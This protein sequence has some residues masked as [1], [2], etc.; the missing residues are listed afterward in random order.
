MFPS[1]FHPYPQHIPNPNH[2]IAKHGNGY[3]ISHPYA[4]LLPFP[5]ATS[6]QSQLKEN[7]SSTQ[8]INQ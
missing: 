4:I 3:K 2:D 6:I 8:W 5:I 7:M 1:R